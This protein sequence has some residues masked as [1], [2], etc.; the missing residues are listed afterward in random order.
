MGEVESILRVEEKSSIR[1]IIKILSLK[2]SEN[3]K[4]K[5][6]GS[7]NVLNKYIIL[8]LNDEDVRSF[9]GLDTVLKEG[10]KLTFL[11]VIAGG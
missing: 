1:D 11:P 5:I 10:D 7:H 8:I 9:N 2:Y 3:F 4:S 6:L